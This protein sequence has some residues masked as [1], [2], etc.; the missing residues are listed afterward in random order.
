MSDN[1]SERREINRLKREIKERDSLISTYQEN[2]VFQE[3]LYNMV[4][5]QKDEQEIFLELMLDKSTDLIVL[6]NTKRQFV[7]GTK[8][9][10]RKLGI[11]PDALFGM[12]FM[13]S[14]SVVLSPET[15]N[16]LFSKLQEA[17]E[18][19]VALKYKENTVLQSGQSY[20]HK[21]SIIPFVNQDGGVI[22]AMLQIYDIAELLKDMEHLPEAI[23]KGALKLDI[24]AGQVFLADKDLLLSP[25]EFLLLLL[26]MQN[27]GET[28]SIETI[29]EKIWG[30][31]TNNYTDIVK[32]TV[33]RLRKKMTGSGY[34]INSIYGNGYRFEE[35]GTTG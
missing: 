24:S 19:G 10:L 4:K 2:A 33:Y 34:I 23:I 5:K 30:I 14:L 29:Y 7:S 12:D 13:D 32:S 26:L 28:M 6:L 3:K 22:G 16:K 11:N 21:I 15:H 31:K 25:K 20:T 27:D 17:L 9:N 8:S 1:K 18:K 35:S